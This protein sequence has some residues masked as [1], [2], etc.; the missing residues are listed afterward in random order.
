MCAAPQTGGEGGRSTDG[1]RRH[2]YRRQCGATLSSWYASPHTHT[3][4]L[5]HAHTLTHTHAHTHTSTH[6][7]ICF[8][9]STLPLLSIISII[10][11]SKTI[12]LKPNT[13]AAMIYSE[14]LQKAR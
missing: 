12:T 2:Q 5:T 7:S 13:D 3:H 6:T 10:F 9:D 4:T 1:E 11:Q 14:F 8:A